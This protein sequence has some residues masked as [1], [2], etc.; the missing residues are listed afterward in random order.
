LSDHVTWRNETIPPIPD[1][2]TPSA[3][4]A[5]TD[6]ENE[7]VD[8]KDL[9]DP[10]VHMRTV[11]KSW[12]G[13]EMSTPLFEE[14]MKTILIKG[15]ALTVAH[16]MQQVLTN[17][18]HGYYRNHQRQDDI[19][20]DDDIDKNE[21]DD[22]WETSPQQ[23]R[24]MIGPKGDFV[25]APEISQIFGESIAV[26]FIT[27]WKAVLFR[28]LRLR[29]I[30]LGPGKG[31]LI[32]DII[33]AAHLLEKGFFKSIREIHLVEQS[34]ALRQMQKEMLQSIDFVE[35]EFF[36][37]QNNS[38]TAG[39]DTKNISD[40]ASSQQSVDQTAHPTIKVKWHNYFSQVVQEVK[41][42]DTSNPKMANLIVAQE[43]LDAL[44]I[45]VFVKTPQ[46]WRE[47]LVDLGAF[48]DDVEELE[49][50]IL[51]GAARKETL[52]PESA[53]SESSSPLKPRL[54]FVTASDVTAAVSTL[55]HV[56]P[57]TGK[58]LDP[59]FDA[60][61][62]GQVLE[63]CPEGILLVQDLAQLIEDHG[64]G[65]ALLI[66]YGQVG[67]TDSLRGYSQHQQVHPLSRPGLVDVTADVDFGA[68][69]HAVN[70]RTP[71]TAATKTTVSE[72]K[73]ETKSEDTGELSIEEEFA[74]FFYE[75]DKKAEKTDTVEE[76]P[77]S[78]TSG[79]S[80][81]PPPP[82][83]AWHGAITAFGPITQGKFLASMGAID[84][85]SRFIENDK[86]TDEEANLAYQALEK[87]VSPEQMGER[88]KVLA[89]SAKKDGIFEP[90]GFDGG[91]VLP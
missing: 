81:T 90:A 78:A 43:F 53:S 14:F 48:A 85:I 88:Y 22:L 34:G 64:G 10:E 25:T 50:D 68:I 59:A 74:D 33:R 66:D 54:R 18:E 29:L 5:Q 60:A 37:P 16:F 57:K 79:E 73:S 6:W 82:P 75:D 40:A 1:F 76:V 46:G 19:S 70:H 17:P 44:P 20:W 72:S 63:V 28:S 36:E 47:R 23:S 69:R 87:L 35:W 77:Q 42:N 30:E 80:D 52:E 21:D 89:I 58:G 39:T 86:T 38:A 55:L 41:Q 71:T 15:K 11:P 13:F 91:D 4:F 24:S 2:N 12:K 67:S 61:P 84:R 7:L 8:F 27:Q 65:C 45:H 62:E 32:H 49:E 51:S 56:D 3:P 26:W 31:T 9:Y 83:M